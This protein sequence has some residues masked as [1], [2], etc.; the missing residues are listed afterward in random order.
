MKS[1]ILG[2]SG[3]LAGPCNAASGFLLCTDTYPGMLIDTGPGVLSALQQGNFSPGDYDVAFTHLHADHCA[4]F[5]SL[6]V[7]R[8]YHPTAK[9]AQRN[10]LFAPGHIA[11][12]LGPLCTD[13]DAPADP[14][15]DTFDLVAWQEGVPQSHGEITITPFAAVHPIEAYSLRVEAADGTVFA[16]SGDTA[17]TDRL[18]DC[19]NDADVLFCEA[20]WGPSSAGKAPAMHMSAAE[21]G[22]IATRANVGKL[23]L[24]HIP[25]WE[26][27][28]ATLAAAQD[29]FSGEVVI[30]AP[31]DHITAAASR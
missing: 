17:P 1:I 11:T 25:P 27:Q 28:A 8:R 24:V 10:M 13:E 7:W 15:S 29:A 18:V 6:L 5:P 22:E 26:D 4:D 2:S 16:F 14:F 21:A 30:A 19:A 23:V 3:S 9:A 31:G 12:R 20:S